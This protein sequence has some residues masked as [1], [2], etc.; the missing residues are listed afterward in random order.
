MIAPFNRCVQCEDV[1][2]NPLCTDCLA[3]QMVVMVGEYDQNLAK[4]IKGFVTDGDTICISC[5]SRMGLCAYCFSKDIYG[6]LKD[7]KST[8]AQE[9]LSRFDFELRKEL[10]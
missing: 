5:G 9:F 7:K 6:F 8:I 2:T 10:V 3:M 1:I 4:Y